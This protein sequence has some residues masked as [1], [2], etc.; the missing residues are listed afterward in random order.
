MENPEDYRSVIEVTRY[1]DPE[2]YREFFFGRFD[3][4]RRGRLTTYSQ[5]YDNEFQLY[6]LLRPAR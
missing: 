5:R 1:R 6:W 3:V 4:A 2:K